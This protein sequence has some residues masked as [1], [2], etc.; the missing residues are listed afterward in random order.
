MSRIGDACIIHFSIT[1]TKLLRL[2]NFKKKKIGLYS[3]KLKG[4]VPVTAL[5]PHSGEKRVYQ[6]AEIQREMQR[7]QQWPPAGPNFLEVLSP[8][9]HQAEDQASSI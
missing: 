6:Q 8:L 4:M 2:N 5:R 3:S 9:H 7:D 1:M